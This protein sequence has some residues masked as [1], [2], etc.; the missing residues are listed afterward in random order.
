MVRIIKALYKSKLSMLFEIIIL[1]FMYGIPLLLICIGFNSIQLL[2][3]NGWNMI[4]FLNGFVL[5]IIVISQLFID[6]LALLGLDKLDEE[7][8]ESRDEKDIANH[9]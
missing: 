4:D 7:I 6:I 8:E 2:F 3:L 1:G 5:I 9:C